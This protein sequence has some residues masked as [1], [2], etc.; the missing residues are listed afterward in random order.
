MPSDAL[1]AA[2]FPAR[3]SSEVLL[4]SLADITGQHGDNVSEGGGEESQSESNGEAESEGE[5]SS[6]GDEGSGRRRVGNT[7]A[8]MGQ[9]TLCLMHP[10]GPTYASK[11]HT[12]CRLCGMRLT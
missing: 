3:L 5:G 10:T 12:Y 6:S 4:R 7:N 11:G 8:G 9:Q 1:A 2:V